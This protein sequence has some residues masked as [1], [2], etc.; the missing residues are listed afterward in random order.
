MEYIKA[1][2][3]GGL[4]CVVGQIILDNTKLTPAHILVSFLTAGVI[5]GGI[6]LYEPLVKFGGAG[7]TVP[8]IGFG[9]ALAQGAIEGAK[10]KGII[11][12]FTGGLQATAGGVAAAIL[13]GYIMAVIFNPKTKN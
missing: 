1:F 12:A 11:G 8:I 7:A 13:F 10:T 5:L 4:I 2:I 9:N 3:V 6:G